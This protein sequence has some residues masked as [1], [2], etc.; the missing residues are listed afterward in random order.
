MSLPPFRG[1]GGGSGL[2]P[3]VGQGLPARFPAQRQASTGSSAPGGGVQSPPSFARQQFPLGGLLAGQGSATASTAR[4]GNLDPSDFPALGAPLTSQPSSLTTPTLLSS[5][6]SSSSYA[7]QAGNH[8]SPLV[9]PLNPPSTTSQPLQ[10]QPHQHQLGHARDFSQDD[11]PALSGPPPTA[12]FPNDLPSTMNGQQPQQLSNGISLLPGGVAPTPR[13]TTTGGGGGGQEQA[14]AVAALQHQQQQQQHRANLLGSMNGLNPQQQQRS[15]SGNQQQDAA[16]KAFGLSKPTAQQQQQQQQPW[17][18]T[19]PSQHAQPP[20]NGTSTTTNIGG[21]ASSPLPPPLDP[22]QQQQQQLRSPSSSGPPPGV[23]PARAVGAPSLNTTTTT[24]G[25]SGAPLPPP[26]SLAPQ[27][28][29]DQVLFSPAD[30]Y[31]L[32]GLLHIIKTTDPDLS[33]LALGSDLTSLGLDLG[34]TDNLY[35]TFITPWS[36]SKAASALNIEPEFHLPSCYNVQPPPAQTKIGNFSDETLFFIFYS[37]PRDAMQEMAA[38]ELYKHNWRY[39]KELRL[40]LTKEAGTEPT[41]K[42]SSYE[43]GSYIIFDPTVWERVRKEFVLE[44][45]ALESRR[46]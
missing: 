33:M 41:Q 26:T 37:Q 46:G 15:A 25:S 10:L 12:T 44:F 13:S 9:N 27:T 11:F 40:W 14:S 23:H 36:D 35:S 32:L 3:G 29:A 22:Q 28:P 38:H 20:I 24:L 16:A 30:R 8:P 5:S 45:S 7:S 21:A 1:A 31:G 39:H 4:E 18:S 34:A 6:S 19:P 2:Y 17:A 43:R 42:T